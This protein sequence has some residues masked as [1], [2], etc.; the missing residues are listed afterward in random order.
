MALIVSSNP[1]SSKLSYADIPYADNYFEYD[2]EAQIWRDASEM[3]KQRALV[4]ATRQI[5]TLNF[6]GTKALPDQPLAFPRRK[7]VYLSEHELMKLKLMISQSTTPL[8]PEDVKRATCEQALYLLQNQKSD[9]TFDKLQ[10]KGIKSYS[11]GDV[12]VTFE[13]S[14]YNASLSQTS[15]KARTYLDQYI[16]RY[17][18]L[19]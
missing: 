11:V 1:N 13:A 6:Q 16:K 9:Q 19:I 2:L 12:S 7:E 18:R 4:T 14:S 10:G 5:D 8:Y 3:D 15:P 17:T